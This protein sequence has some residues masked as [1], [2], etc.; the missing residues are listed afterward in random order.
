[1]LHLSP[2]S[3]IT[4]SSSH[5][6]W[7]Y[8]NLVNFL[9]PSADTVLFYYKLILPLFSSCSTLLSHHADHHLGAILSLPSS[10]ILQSPSDCISCI[11]HGPSLCIF[12]LSYKCYTAVLSLKCII[13][14]IF[15]SKWNQRIVSVTF[16]D[17]LNCIISKFSVV[18]Y[19]FTVPKIFMQVWAR[20][21]L[22]SACH[23]LLFPAM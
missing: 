20:K 19:V 10:Y 14:H 23:T 4:A 11:G 7:S 22:E 9:L 1:M 17:E 2:P 6:S 12:S 13:V 8:Y 15:I 16:L 3:V 5:N 21:S 18:C